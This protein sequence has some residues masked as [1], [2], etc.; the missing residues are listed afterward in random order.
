MKLLRLHK[1]E[2]L[3][4][5]ET[6]LADYQKPIYWHIR[7]MVVDHDDAA[8]GLQETFIKVYQGLSGL[9]DVASLRA[10]IYRIATNECLRFLSRRRETP[11]SQVD[12]DEALQSRL[13]ES[14]YVDYDDKMAVDFQRALL[15][16]SS[17]QRTVFNLRYYDELSYEEIS[18]IVGS[19]PATLKVAYHNAKEKIEKYLLNE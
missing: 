12:G 13:M 8:D 1:R 18:E 7:R 16:L 11:L 5:F 19:T 10:W 6:V 14:D 15:T 4:T 9:K 3:P 17:Q 2:D